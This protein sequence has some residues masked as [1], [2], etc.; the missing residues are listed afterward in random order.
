MS[1]H[2][3][4]HVELPANDPATA[5][6]FYADLFGWQLQKDDAL[7]YLMFQAEGGPGG[8]FNKVDGEQWK[9]GEVVIYVSTD[10]ID[11][12]LA[13]AE[14]LGGRTLMPKTVIPNNGWISILQDPTGNKIGL[15]TPPQG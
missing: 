11:V 1:K 2:P 14:A 15:Y 7:D 4:V 3:I 9:P 10:D 8:G 6:R 13:Q 5:G 12:T